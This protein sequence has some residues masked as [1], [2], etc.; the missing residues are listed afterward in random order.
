MDVMALLMS[1]APVGLQRVN[2]LLPT[3]SGGVSLATFMAIA[4]YDLKSQH[5][6]NLK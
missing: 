4:V 5:N 6:Q 2:N 1:S 3:M